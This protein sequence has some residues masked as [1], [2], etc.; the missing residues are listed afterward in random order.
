MF[1]VATTIFLTYQP[2]QEKLTKSD[3][4]QLPCFL[5]NLDKILYGG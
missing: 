4:F 5:S 2:D 1:E 3:N